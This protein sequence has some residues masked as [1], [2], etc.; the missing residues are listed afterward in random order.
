M[1]NNNMSLLAIMRDDVNFQKRLAAKVADVKEDK[2]KILSFA[3][4]YSQKYK[5]E[6][7]EGDQ[8]R[9]NLLTEGSKNGLSESQVLTSYG[10][11]LPAKSTPIL[12]MLYFLLQESNNDQY[13]GEAL[14][15]KRDRLNEYLQTSYKTEDDIIES[16]RKL[17]DDLTILL[18]EKTSS[19]DARANVNR[20]FEEENESRPSDESVECKEIEDVSQFLYGNLTLDQFNKIKKLKA[21][22]QSENEEEAFQAYRKAIQLCKENNLE[23][24]RIPCYVFK[25]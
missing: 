24:D 19:T 7:E 13:Y 15:H 17:M 18:Q 6:V 22:A 12:N 25:K 3:D 10:R 16:D 4:S 14:Y 11:F 20:M 21:L 23:Y 1:S 8:L 9:T 5:K 2:N